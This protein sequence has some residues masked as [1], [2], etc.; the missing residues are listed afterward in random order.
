MSK[1]IMLC[2]RLCSGKSTY[3]AT[4]RDELG[5]VV[6]S[7]DELMISLLGRETGAMH[8]EY[9]CRAKQYICGKA[10]D[11][12]RAGADVVL[13]QGFW[14]RAERDSAREFFTSRGVDCEL[15]YLRISDEE[16]ERRI[17]KRNAE[18]AAGRSDAYYVDDGLKA[19]FTAMFEEPTADEA[20]AVI[21]V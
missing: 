1:V 2:G 16:W 20:D 19:K 3:S 6:L 14:S 13:D 8:D 15:R 4:L 10:A 7:V 18:V 9:V 12:A 5:C 11:I 21:E 17:A